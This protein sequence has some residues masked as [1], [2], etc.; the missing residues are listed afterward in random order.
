METDL[1]IALRAEHEDFCARLVS[2]AE[3]GGPLGEAADEA[4]R[5]LQRL[6]VREEQLV[7]PALTLLP[8]LEGGRR[9]RGMVQALSRGQRLKEELALILSTQ[10]QLRAALAN[11]RSIAAELRQRQYEC[12]AEALLQRAAFERR[13]L[14]L[15]LLVGEHVRART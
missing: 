11:L 7:L 2:A 8:E 3:Q 6:F 5:L 15:A 4:A 1:A 10:T 14:Y 12:L 13:M 9:P